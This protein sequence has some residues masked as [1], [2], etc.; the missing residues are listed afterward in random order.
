MKT[1]VTFLL[2]AAVV[3]AWA[4][5][6]DSAYVFKHLEIA[7][8][9]ATA[10]INST[11]KCVFSDVISSKRLPFGFANDVVYLCNTPEEKFKRNVFVTSAGNVLML[12]KL[13]KVATEE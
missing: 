12:S 11:E 9:R 1:I 7:S 10:S 13:V 3:L 4:P 2:G 6:M 5:W 8:N